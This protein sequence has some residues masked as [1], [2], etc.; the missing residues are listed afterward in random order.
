MLIPPDRP[1]ELP[2]ML[3][4]LARGEAITH[5]ETVRVRYDGQMIPVSLTISPIRDAGGTII[6][7]STI[8]RDITAR[9]QAEAALRDSEA[10]QQA[11]LQTAADGIITID[12][13]GTIES[14]NPA[15]ERLFGYTADEVMG[16]N[17]S[18]LMP[19]PY[20]EAHDGYLARY[21]QTGEPHIIG[22]GREVRGLRR[23]GT[24]FHMALAVSEVCLADRRL[25]T[26]IVHDLSARVQA[27][28]ALQQAHDELEQRVRDR[29]AALQ[30][31]ND[32][33]RSFAYIVSHDLRAPLIN[34]HGFAKELRTACAVLTQALPDSGAP[35]GGAA[36]GSRSP[37]LSRKTFLKPW[38]S[39]TP[40]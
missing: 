12:E 11:I 3:A 40:P 13:Q 21:C 18:M 1:D 34:L 37:V 25:F 16:H 15:A 4:R 30:E 22:I 5:Y 17:I 33:I 27:E 35:A 6:G 31:A 14:F 8:A 26:G 10:R 29:T 38:A 9:Q 24:I 39:S 28:E 19:S 23:D 20:R 7:A 2:A 36:R 32:D